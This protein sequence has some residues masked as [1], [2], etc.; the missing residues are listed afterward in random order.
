MLRERGAGMKEDNGVII[1]RLLE[2]G[3]SQ[4]DLIELSTDIIEFINLNNKMSKNIKQRA[5]E[6]LCSEKGVE[7]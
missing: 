6:E 2:E 4:L 3:Y 1:A 5:G 7:E